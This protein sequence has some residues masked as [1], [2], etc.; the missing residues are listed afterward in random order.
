MEISCSFHYLTNR[1]NILS[2]FSS[3]GDRIGILTYFEEYFSKYLR[4][5]EYVRIA[6]YYNILKLDKS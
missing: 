6:L 5:K 4:F 1:E 2:D 3:F